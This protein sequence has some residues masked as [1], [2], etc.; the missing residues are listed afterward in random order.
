[1]SQLYSLLYPYSCGDCKGRLTS[2]AHAVACCGAPY[3]LVA[4]P[5]LFCNELTDDS[6]EHFIVAKDAYVP[7]WQLVSKQRVVGTAVL[8]HPM[9][10]FQSQIMEAMAMSGV[11]TPAQGIGLKRFNVLWHRKGES[12]DIEVDSLQTFKLKAVDVDHAR[13]LFQSESADVTIWSIDQ[14]EQGAQTC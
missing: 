8:V 13:K 12:F 5:D 9:S 2:L 14:P 7:G 11:M 10:H 3:V 4:N 1:M 6:P